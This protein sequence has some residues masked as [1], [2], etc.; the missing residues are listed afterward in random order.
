MG[1]AG[2]DFVEIENHRSCSEFFFETCERRTI[3]PLTSNK[4]SSLSLDA[5]AGRGT[6]AVR[7]PTKAAMS[8]DMNERRFM[9]ISPVG[10]ASSS[11]G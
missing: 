6:K 5:A 1:L 9:N 7:R 10:D 4:S 3:Q 8:S 11:S 2:G